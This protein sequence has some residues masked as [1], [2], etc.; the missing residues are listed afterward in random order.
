MNNGVI[1]L[2]YGIINILFIDCLINTVY[3]PDT[4]TN[5]IVIM[6][7][8]KSFI[9]FITIIYSYKLNWLLGILVGGICFIL[10]IITTYK[11]YLIE[12]QIYTSYIKL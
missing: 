10:G 9:Y 12:E 1:L 4:I 6:D 7:M 11:N 2:H 3:R 8:I 5:T